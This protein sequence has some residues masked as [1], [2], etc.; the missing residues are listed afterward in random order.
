MH[1]D[2]IKKSL[3]VVFNTNPTLRILF[4]F[5]LDVLL[6]RSWHIRREIKSWAAKAPL[7]ARILDAGAGFG[8]YVYYMSKLNPSWQI[9]GVDVKQEQVKDCNNFFEKIGASSRVKYVEGDLTQ[10]V[11]QQSVDAIV[12]VDVME[13]IEADTDVF[14]NFYASLQTGGVLFISTPSDLGGSDVH[15]D[16]D[17]SFVGEHVRDGYNADDI[18]QKLKQAGF[19]SVHTYYSYGTYGSISWRLSMK[20]PIQMLNITKLL[21][22]VLPVYY[23]IVFPWCLL[24][25]YIDVYS[26]NA[27]GTGLIVKAFK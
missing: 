10:F 23:A 11:S 20:Y 17:E 12:C 24:F 14:A 19:S 25:N 22:V 8:Q 15:D 1:Y 5:L 4:Y 9:V 18:S 7:H 2:P 16:H 27:K 21:F 6:L 3:G 13:H 26:N